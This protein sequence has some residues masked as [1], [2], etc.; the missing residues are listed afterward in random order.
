MN[1]PVDSQS[2]KTKSPIPQETIGKAPDGEQP[3]T[4]HKAVVDL[5]HLFPEKFG[6][7][8]VLKLLGKGGMGSVFL[9]EDPI[10]KRK[11]AIKTLRAELAS[12]AVCKERFL[13]EAQIVSALKHD[14]IVTIYAVG[15]EYGIPYLVMEYLEGQSLEETIQKKKKWTWVQ[16]IRV[17]REIARALSIAHAQNLIHRDIKPANI[18]LEAVDKATKKTRVKI[19]DFGLARYVEQSAGLTQAGMVVG[20]PH[21][22]S[23]EQ[24][25]GKD[26]DPRSDLFSMGVVLYR[27]STKKMPFDGEDTLALLTALAV[28]TPKPMREHNPDVPAEFDELVMKLLAK[29]PDD[30][31]ASA[32]I[33]AEE[34]Q[35]LYYNIAEAT[36][37]P[38]NSGPLPARPAT[39]PFLKAAEPDTS[40]VSGTTSQKLIIILCTLIA[41]L[42]FAIIALLFFKISAG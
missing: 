3:T 20:T 15:E 32:K 28:D 14:H 41:L 11:M 17:G 9:A 27:L 4:E 42:S 7:Y 23:P 30:R 34:L 5:D 38:T 19:L 2:P 8:R 13:R 29:N 12:N 39:D 26:L 1:T 36:G 22:V 37:E 24:A 6:Q 10:L 16:I 21:Y 25:R 40:A 31:P 33:V 18:W 35:N